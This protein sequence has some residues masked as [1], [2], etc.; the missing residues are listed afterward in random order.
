MISGV[1]RCKYILLHINNDILESLY[2][3]G[4]FRGQEVLTEITLSS[5]V[6]GHT[7]HSTEAHQA[8]HEAHI[9]GILWLTNVQEAVSHES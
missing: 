6:S 2:T 8:T 1:I 9:K 3:V 4:F 5:L 7:L